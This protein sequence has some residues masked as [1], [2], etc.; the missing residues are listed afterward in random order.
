MEIGAK[1][2]EDGTQ[3]IAAGQAGSA[4][5][6]AL[7]QGLEALGEGEHDQHGQRGSDEDFDERHP[8]AVLW[9]CMGRWFGDCG[10]EGRL[11]GG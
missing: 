1:K 10:G 2:G 11:G 4:G 8:V 3:L 9:G 5:C 7:A 6:D